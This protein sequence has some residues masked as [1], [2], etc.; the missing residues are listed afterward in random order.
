MEQVNT[1][2]MAYKSIEIGCVISASPGLDG[3]ADPGETNPG[4]TTGSLGV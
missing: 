1:V 3:P 4:G 2:G